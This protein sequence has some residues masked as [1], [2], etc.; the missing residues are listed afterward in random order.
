M[1]HSIKFLAAIMLILSAAL[2]ARAQGSLSLHGTYQEFYNITPLSAFPYGEVSDY[3]RQLGGGLR[4]NIGLN[5]KTSMSIGANFVYHGSKAFHYNDAKAKNYMGYLDLQFNHYLAGAYNRKGGFYAFGGL[6]A[7]QY[8]IVW[9][10]FP[11]EIPEQGN[12]FYNR[13]ALFVNASAGLG[14]EVYISNFYLFAD[15]SINTNLNHYVDG[16]TI[17][18]MPMRNFWT[19]KAGIRLPFGQVE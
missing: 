17:K 8:W 18:E 13:H 4:Y 15:G 5:F 19:V 14:T 11:R 2:T 3:P 9:D 10:K 6:T 1:K 12:Y 7:G 16:T